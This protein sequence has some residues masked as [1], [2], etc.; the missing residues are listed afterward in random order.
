VRALLFSFLAACALPHVDPLPRSIDNEAATVAR[1]N[2]TCETGAPYLDENIEWYPP[3]IG[4]GVVISERHV[5]TAAHVVNCPDFPGVIITLPGGKWQ[6]MNEQRNDSMFG[7]GA[8]VSRLVIS[9][10]DH[11]H[12]NIAP[13]KLGYDAYGST[14]CAVTRHG[15]ECGTRDYPKT[16]IRGMHTIPGDSGAPVYTTQGELAGIVSSGG[17]YTDGEFFTRIVEIDPS[18][19][20]GT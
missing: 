19:L 5:L 20:E 3:R 2:T 12:L 10:A 9:S 6:F 15:R 7:S 17:N 11:F 18:W 8:D 4:T 1:V 14:Y 13:P 16:V